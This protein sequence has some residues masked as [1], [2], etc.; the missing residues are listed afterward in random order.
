MSRLTAPQPQSTNTF[1]SPATITLP[2]P[3]RSALGNG[4]PVPR[5]TTSNRSG[6][7][8]HSCR[9]RQMAVVARSRLA[10]LIGAPVEAGGYNAIAIATPPSAGG[11]RP[12]HGHE[13]PGGSYTITHRENFFSP[14]APAPNRCR[15]P[16]HVRPRPHGV[17]FVH[18]CRKLRLGVFRRCS[19]SWSTRLR[20]AHRS[21]SA[22]RKT[23]PFPAICRWRPSRSLSPRGPVVT[24]GLGHFI[25]EDAPETACA[26]IEQFI[27]IT[28]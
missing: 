14:N 26:L 12:L 8:P 17:R 24:R 28:A 18:R 6:M 19:K 1:V 16:A 15:G 21:R 27:Q 23:G 25:Q 3:Q 11:C 2:A 7:D 10:L 9:G 20:A 13:F 5:K 4:L 22:N